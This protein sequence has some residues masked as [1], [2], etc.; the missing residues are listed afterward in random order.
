MWRPKRHTA[1]IARR[2][3]PSGAALHRAVAVIQLVYCTFLVLG[4]VALPLT[5]FLVSPLLGI[6]LGIL[7][8]VLAV[9]LLIATVAHYDLVRMKARYK[10]SEDEL[11]EFMRLVPYLSSAPALATLPPRERRRQARD[12]AAAAVRSGRARPA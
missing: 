8:L 3:R 9:P 1:P 10:L 11:D 5:G 6:V 4:V 7:S 12:A 2:Y